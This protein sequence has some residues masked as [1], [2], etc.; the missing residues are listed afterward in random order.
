MS[1]LALACFLGFVLGCIFC[2]L[3]GLRRPVQ[4][5]PAEEPPVE[6]EP[7]AEPRVED[8][9]NPGDR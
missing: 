2:Y 8:G 9:P 5:V 1:V 4:V 6:Y 7:T 3:V